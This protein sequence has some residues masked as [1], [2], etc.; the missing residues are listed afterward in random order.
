[1]GQHELTKLKAP[2]AGEICSR[3]E[4]K[5]EARPLLSSGMGPREFVELLLANKQ[6]D[7]AIAFIAHG[8]PP[9]EAIWWGCLCLQYALGDNWSEVDK[10]A[11]RA[12]VQWV[13]VPTE[14]NR[15]AAQ[16]LAEAAGR[17]SPAGTLATAAYR[18]GG[19][20][21][22]PIIPLVPPPPFAPAKAVAN[23]IRL[24]SAKLDP[25]KVADTQGLFVELGIGVAEGRSL[26]PEARNT[27]TMPGWA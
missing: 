11:A 13:M 10:A 21:A 12:A 16:M 19:S 24:A 5:K 7:S 18:T 6:N 20:P 4:L 25:D 3:F 26:W 27:V 22:P 23:A 9:R 8:L 15:A 17:V 14:E 2:T 1:V